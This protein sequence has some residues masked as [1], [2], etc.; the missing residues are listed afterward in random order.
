[1]IEWS[2]SAWG[3]SVL[4]VLVSA[5]TAWH[6]GTWRRRADLDL[7]FFEHGGMWGDLLLLPV[8]NAVIVPHVEIGA[9]LVAPGVAAAAVSVWLHVQ[10][11]GGG[12]GRPWREHLWPSRAHA[13]WHGDLSGAGWLHVL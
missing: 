11:Y 1:M 9:W 5:L 6:A 7:G 3:V 4:A 12:G 10:W 8:A 2:W 13:T